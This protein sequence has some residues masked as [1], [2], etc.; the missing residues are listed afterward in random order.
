LFKRQFK[1]FKAWK[2]F[3]LNGFKTKRFAHP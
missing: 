2:Q 1:W 3:S